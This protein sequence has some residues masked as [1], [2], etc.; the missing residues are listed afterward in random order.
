VRLRHLFYR[1]DVARLRATI[2]LWRRY[3][4]AAPRGVVAGGAGAGGAAPG[5]GSVAVAS[6]ASGSVDGRSASSSLARQSSIARE[7]SCV[8]GVDLVVFG[9]RFIAC[10]AQLAVLH[11]H[12]AALMSVRLVSSG[13][14]QPAS[15]TTIASQIRT[16]QHSLCAGPRHWRVVPKPATLRG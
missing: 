3:G 5:G 2:P 1:S 15:V 4:F 16:S 7:I 12:V 6:S 10:S 13:S 11:A 14:L 8:R 9:T